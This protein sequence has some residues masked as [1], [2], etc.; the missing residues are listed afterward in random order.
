M[1]KNEIF[2]EKFDNI[3]PKESFD[4]DFNFYWWCYYGNPN[5]FYD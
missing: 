4:L 3:N 5:N 1:Q 2:L